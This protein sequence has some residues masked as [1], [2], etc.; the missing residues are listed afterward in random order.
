MLH[1]YS[2]DITNIEL[3]EKFAYPFHYTPHKLSL[4][5]CE[6]LKCFI[7]SQEDMLNELQFGKMFGVLVVQA[8]DGKIG[9][10]CSFSGGLKESN[11]KKHFVP[12]ICDLFQSNHF[13]HSEE[14]RISEINSKIDDLSNND[15]FKSLK[16]Q[17]ILESSKALIEINDYKELMAASKQLRIQRKKDNDLLPELA[18]L[19]KE[20]QFQKAELKRME[21]KW[22]IILE[23]IQS[24]ISVFHENMSKLKIE[25]KSR[26]SLLQQQF[27]E[28]FN[29][30]NATGESI[31]L[32]LL[33]SD[34]LQ[35]TPPSGAGECAAPKLLQYA[36]LNNLKPIALAEFWWG[37]SPKLEIRHHEHYYPACR[38]KCKPIL[39]FMLKGLIVENNPLE[40]DLFCDYKL[41]II[42]DDKYFLAINKP[43]GMLSVNGLFEISS[44]HTILKKTY[45]KLD[46]YIAHRLDMSTS[47]VLLIAKSLAVYKLLQIQFQYRLLN[48]CYVAVLDGDCS[49]ADKQGEINLPIRLN[50]LNRPCQVVDY[51]AG[52]EAITKYNI[53]SVDNNETRIEFYPKTGR[54]HQLRVHSSHHEGLNAPIKG[55]MLYG[56]WSDRLY[57]HA[58][59]L[60]FI[61]PVTK[62]IV[63]IKIEPDF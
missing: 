40:E 10:L 63:C 53:I 4:I 33:F 3:P 49:F 36:F 50:P 27:F 18:Q 47:G 46:L 11:F 45:P 60:E 23:G 9:Y 22:Q 5:A 44:V 61:H 38:G 56:K 57:L 13:F 32:S 58:K 51:M 26:S 30:L 16:E 42:Y 55:D 6:E 20:S 39:E 62:E 31:N 19:I 59:S 24:D 17:H 25:R 41:E 1:Q 43:A 34:T 37:N 7:S 54:T 48:K 2:S 14:I 15:A 52:K 12:S 8:I 29:I 21:R 28:Q 35:K